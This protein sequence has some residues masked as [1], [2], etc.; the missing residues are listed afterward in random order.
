MW[1][2]LALLLL[3]PIGLYLRSRSAWD[4]PTDNARNELVF[5]GRHRGYGAYVL[6]QEHDRTM[7]F[8]L[9]ASMLFT[10]ALVGGA[11]LMSGNGTPPPS[12]PKAGSG[13]IFELEKDPFTYSEVPEESGGT[14]PPEH[15][16]LPEV[17]P[18]TYVEAG[19]DDKPL[20]RDT[21]P[22]QQPQEDLMATGTVPGSDTAG[23]GA[24]PGGDGNA[25]T[26]GGGNGGDG[27]GAGGKQFIDDWEA[28]VKPA[29]PGGEKAMIS[30]I[31]NN[32][33]FPA[34]QERG[35]QRV[36]VRFVVDADGRVRNVEAV[37]RYAASY[38][39]AAERLIKRMPEWTPASMNGRPV[40]CR[41]VLPISFETI[42]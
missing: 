1:Y 7:G 40:P 37:G 23:G 28:D 3:V 35:R 5:E 33:V 8:A 6:R 32:V 11:Y 17:M 34:A 41:L 25:G 18:D 4:D 9:L 38:G 16:T 2:L 26:R 13:T 31:Q 10:A 24:L 27:I 20:E 19:K 22:Q 14:A 39:R 36:H 12:P 30:W 29:F 21:V 42:D 15:S